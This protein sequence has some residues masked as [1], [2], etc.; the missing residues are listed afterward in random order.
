[1][2][3]KQKVYGNIEVNYKF[4][5]IAILEKLFDKTTEKMLS[6]SNE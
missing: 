3:K 5:Q 4:I 1:M 2:K 6:L